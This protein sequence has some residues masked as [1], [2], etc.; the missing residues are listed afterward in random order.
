MKFCNNFP[1]EKVPAIDKLYVL[2]TSR[3]DVSTRKTTLVFISCLK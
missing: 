2:V 3:G 1:S